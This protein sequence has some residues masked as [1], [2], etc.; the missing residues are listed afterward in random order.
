MKRDRERR[1]VDLGVMRQEAD[2]GI[3]VE[4]RLGERFIGPLGDNWSVG[5]AIRRRKRGARIDDRYVKACDLRDRR[6]R[7]RDMHGPDEG[8]PRRRRLNGQKV[9]LALMRD[10]CAFAH[11]QR[12]LQFRAKRV[13]VDGF[14]ANESL[15]AVGQTGDDGA[16]A[17]F[18]SSQ[19]HRLEDVEPHQAS[20]ST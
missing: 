7:L 19:V 4:R 18:A 17:A 6:Q 5:K 10:R 13:G 14:G 11:A 16:G 12:R 2:R 15:L 1:V 20:F 8:Q 3:A 9:F